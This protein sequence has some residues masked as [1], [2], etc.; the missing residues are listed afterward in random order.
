MNK[1]QFL[2]L[3]YKDYDTPKKADKIL[4]LAKKLEQSDDILKKVKDIQAF[5]WNLGVNDYFPTPDCLIK[6]L[7]TLAE[8]SNWFGN[9][10]EPSAGTGNIAEAINEK[11]NYRFDYSDFDCVEINP[12]FADI[13]RDKNLKVYNEDFL[14]FKPDKD[15]GLI[16]MNPP[17]SDLENPI[18]K[19]IS[20]IHDE[21]YIFCVVPKNFEKLEK[22]KKLVDEYGLIV[23]DYSHSF[24]DCGTNIV[25]DIAEYDIRKIN[26]YKSSLYDFFCNNKV[27]YPLNL[28]SCYLTG[29]FGEEI[30]KI[31]S[32]TP[33]PTDK[34]LFNWLIDFSHLQTSFPLNFCKMLIQPYL[35]F[36]N[37]LREFYIDAAEDFFKEDAA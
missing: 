26:M 34:Q 32:K 15:Y 21:G 37:V 31:I 16:I 20:L 4:K 3:T 17:F 25:C 9:I 29:D 23:Y 10:L 7:L 30:Y 12:V 2:N 24:R 6:D 22:Y 33:N 35:M 28:F 11:Y 5:A 27:E 14:N 1:E 18:K 13:L 36:V 19:A 8:N